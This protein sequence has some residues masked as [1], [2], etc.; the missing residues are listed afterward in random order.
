[1]R[2][3]WLS[4]IVLMF[5]CVP[6]AMG[7]LS[8]PTNLTATVVSSTSVRLAWTDTQGNPAEDGFGIE[9]SLAPTSGFALV[10]TAARNATS[11]VDSGLVTGRAY[12]YRVQTKRGKDSSGYSNVA[13]A[14]PVD[15]TA[16][17]VPT[18]LNDTVMSCSQINLSWTGSTDSESGVANYRLY[19][20]NAFVRQV[21]AQFTSTSDAGLAGSST[22]QYQVSAVDGVGNESSR[23]NVATGTTPVCVSTTTAPPATTTSTTR[24]STTSTTVVT[25]STTTST[26]LSGDHTVPS[27][28]TGLG[29]TSVTCSSVN[30]A[31]F[32]STD[33]GGSGLAG[34][35]LYRNNAF[36]KQ[37]ATTT[38]SDTGLAASTVYGYQVSAVDNAGNESA[39]SV[40]AN[41][42]TTA[43]TAGTG[44]HLWSK[45]MGGTVLADAVVPYGVAV[46]G[47]GNV[48]VTGVYYGTVNFG[49]GNIA[50]AG[51]ADM[52]IAKWSAGGAIQWV[53]HFGDAADQYGTAIATDTAGNIYVTGYFFGTVDFG[54]GPLTSVGYDILL[55]KYNSA[56]TCQWSKRMGGTSTEMGQAIAVDGS[57][58]V[59]VA[60][61]Y[62]ATVDFGGGPLT[63]VGGYDGFIAK[64][65]TN[66]GYVWQKSVGGAALDTITGLGVDAQGNP[67]AVGHF[68][69]TSNFGGANLTSAGSNDIF[70][71]RYN[72]AGV[73]QWSNRYGDAN[74]QR[75]YGGAVDA[76]GNVALTGYFTGQISFGGPTFTNVAGAD[77]FLAKLT[78]TGAHSWSK[79]FGSALSYGEVGEAVAFDGAGNVLLTGEIVQAVDLGGGAVIPTTVTYDAFIAKYSPTG[80]Y[81]W[82]KRFVADWDDH[83]NGVAA[84]SNGNVLIT[85]DF[86]DAVN[87][88]GGL[89]SSPG[90]SDG[91]L[92]KLT[93]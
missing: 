74:D 13:S 3:G 52:F 51:R 31:W 69:G 57:S 35:K 63:S 49:N 1:M 93:P 25:A 28:P 61:Q 21:A 19:R 43:C 70:V 37:V 7:A 5:G 27:V 88:G 24:P 67:T 44:T 46:D 11:F 64:Y 23:S 16:P 48:Y 38:T 86:Y 77:I 41:T 71:A 60:G 73:H 82:S 8:A 2:L 9:R 45:D 78:P 90:G 72:A 50:S 6:T 34:Y 76:A 10:A 36:V 91:F 87:F 53:K 62:A 65:N 92:V 14:T 33:A 20:N 81:Q 42:N 84:D 75:A 22:Y 68:S 4:F 15:M 89:L 80:V 55:A 12:Y 58:N 39:R 54:A 17:T 85:G 32:A 59:L 47:S 26:T 29:V 66:G 79:A 83:G 18:G 40:T 30:L 56:G